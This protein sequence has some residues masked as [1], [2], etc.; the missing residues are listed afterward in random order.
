MNKN[1]ILTHVDI[2]VFC[3]FTHLIFFI[4]VMY[5]IMTEE[6]VIR[7]FRIDE[8]AGRDD[9]DSRMTSS[10]VSFFMFNMLTTF[11]LCKIW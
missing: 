9:S 3:F 11:F 10:F 7:E 1:S 2:S 4:L 5:G 8:A 6:L